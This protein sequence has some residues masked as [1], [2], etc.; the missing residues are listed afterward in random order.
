MSTKMAEM[1]QFRLTSA[2]LFATVSEPDPDGAAWLPVQGAAEA[3]TAVGVP[4]L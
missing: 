3:V 1:R 2:I 4:K